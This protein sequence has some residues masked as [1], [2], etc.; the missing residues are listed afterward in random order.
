MLNLFHI[1]LRPGFRIYCHC[2]SVFRKGH[3]WYSPARFLRWR[4]IPPPNHWRYHWSNGLHHTLNAPIIHR[5]H[6]KRGQW[7]AA[8]GSTT[9]LEKMATDSPDFWCSFSISINPIWDDFDASLKCLAIRVRSLLEV[10][11]YFARKKPLYLKE[12]ENTIP[13]ADE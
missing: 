8:K 10:L 13:S 1:H 12:W 9:M 6:L 5:S 11:S 7:N 2:I 4:I 3:F